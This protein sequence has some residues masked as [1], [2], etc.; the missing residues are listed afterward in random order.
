MCTV[1]LPP[2]VNPI[3]VKYI[4]SYIISYHI[5]SCHVMS[6]H[7]MPYHIIYHI[8]YHVMSYHIISYHIS[9][10]VMSCHVISYII[11]HVMSYHIIY[12]I[13]SYHTFYKCTATFRTQGSFYTHPTLPVSNSVP[14]SPTHSSS[15]IPSFRAVQSRLP[16]TSLN[17]QCH[18]HHNSC[19][20]ISNGA[21]QSCEYG[22]CV[23]QDC[24]TVCRCASLGDFVVVR[25]SYSVLTQ[26]YIVQY[27]R[28]HT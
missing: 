15:S 18:W 27:S 23:H 4:I 28:L 12:R 25:T 7:A 24:W 10:H 22:M 9:Y 20:C 5:M 8:I 1:L 14:T 11:Y 16:S 21:T 6:C 2:G 13:I 17:R 26:S 19:C 3:A